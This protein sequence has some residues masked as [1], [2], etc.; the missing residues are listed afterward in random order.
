VGYSKEG[1]IVVACRLDRHPKCHLLVIRRRPVDPRHECEARTY[2]M[3]GDRRCTITTWAHMHGRRN[4]LSGLPRWNECASSAVCSDHRRRPGIPMLR[5]R[6]PYL[7]HLHLEP[8]RH[9]IH[10]LQ[11]V[12]LPSHRASNHDLEGHLRTTHPTYQ[13]RQNHNWRPKS[14]L[15]ERVSPQCC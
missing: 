11:G 12:L 1:D 9:G 15:E 14:L 5:R 3:A 6:H 2:M 4:G 8:T 10:E 7:V 13:F